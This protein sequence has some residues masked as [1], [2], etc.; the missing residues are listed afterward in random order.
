MKTL[1]KNIIII[2]FLFSILFY[3]NGYADYIEDILDFDTG[4]EKR[5]ID[6]KHI[7]Y[8][9]IRSEKYNKVQSELKTADIYLRTWIITNYK[10]WEYWYYQTQGIIKNYNSF[11]YYTNQFFYYLQQKEYYPNYTNID[12]EVIKSYKNMKIYYTKVKNLTTKRGLN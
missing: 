5:E 6:L 1:F 7:N 11:V 3:N 10:S 12:D 8:I 4:I 2:S 9:T